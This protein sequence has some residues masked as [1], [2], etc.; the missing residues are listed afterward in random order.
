[1]PKRTASI[2]Q[3]ALE[4]NDKF[5]SDVYTEMKNV[6][7]LDEEEVLS[8][9]ILTKCFKMGHSRIPIFRKQNEVNYCIGLLYVKDLILIDPD[10]NLPI[11][12]VLQQF[13]HH[14]TP[15]D[16]W[17]GD[18]LQSVLQ[19]FISSRQHLAFVKDGTSNSP[20]ARKGI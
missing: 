8:F 11:K 5:V 13:D 20:N 9:E 1:M 6:F 18:D 3:G 16:V 10:D 2:L 15:I 12:K 14:H 4:L 17:R 7:W 19:T